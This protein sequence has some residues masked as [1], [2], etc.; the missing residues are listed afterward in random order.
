MN[1]QLYSDLV[2]G[3]AEHLTGKQNVEFG[4]LLTL[5]KTSGRL[6]NLCGLYALTTEGT[7]KQFSDVAETDKQVNQMKRDLAKALVRLEKEPDHEVA[8]FAK[9]L[10]VKYL[11]QMQPLVEDH[12]YDVSAEMAKLFNTMVTSNKFARRTNNNEFKTKLK[13]RMSEFNLSA[14]Q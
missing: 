14:L 8:T 2:H 12:V 7:Y 11:R 1:Q 3:W 6:R 4:E 5:S 9:S 13:N 10:K